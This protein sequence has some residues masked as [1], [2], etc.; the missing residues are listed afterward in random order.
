MTEQG[1]LPRSPL[2]TLSIERFKGKTYVQETIV[3]VDPVRTDLLFNNPNRL[4]WIAINE[5]ANDIRLSSSPDINGTS[6]WLLM[7][8]GGIISLYWEEDGEAVG[9]S[10]YAIANVAASQVRIREVIRL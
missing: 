8:S 2:E 3:R 9:Y 7:S 1:Y 4:F 5:G 10:V 6:G